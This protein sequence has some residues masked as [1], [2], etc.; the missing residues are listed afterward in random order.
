MK[1]TPTTLGNRVESID[2]LRGFAL[3]GIFV[4]NMLYF[5]LPYLYMDPFTWFSEPSDVAMFKGIKI[6]VEGSFYPI[7]AILFGYGVNMQYEKAA[8]LGNPFAPIMAR[9]FGIMLL[10]GLFHAL[11][12]WYGDI[13]FTY[14]LM[15]FIMIAFVRIPKK[16]MLPIASVLYIVPSGLTYVGLYYL[17]KMDP[18]ALREGYANIQQIE[19]SISAYAKGTYGE[20]FAFRFSEWIVYG[21]GSS[22][23]AFFFILPLIMMGAGLSKW[24]VIERAGEMKGKIVGVTVVALAGGIWLK[25]IP[26]IGAP[27]IDAITL[28]M[29]F[30]GPILAAGYVGIMLLLCQ[31][32]LFRTVFRPVSKAGRM[33]LTTYITQSIIATTIFY[34]YGFGLYG[35]L[36]L[37]TGTW[38]AV[39]VFAIQV[40]FAELW[41]SKFKMGP[42]EWVWRKATY[43][44]K[45][46][47]INGQ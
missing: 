41:L 11:F 10:F 13:L 28:Q 12:I 32:P 25:A 24:K 18:D 20:I 15:G 22:L 1:L 42:L 31:I 6:F 17:N 4:A 16:W 21:L 29:Q 33:S 14:A 46:P 34:A 3:L 27:T 8:A 39:G 19:L 38:I 45:L 43:G 40:I 5:Q 30:G 23:M 7:F 35:K 44:K 26:F 9:R 37:A 36:D 47:R 2:M